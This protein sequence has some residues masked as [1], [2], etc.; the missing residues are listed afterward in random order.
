MNVKNGVQCTPDFNNEELLRYAVE[1]GMISVPHIQNILEMSRKE[2]YLKQHPY[3]IWQGKDGKWCTYLPDEDKGRKFIK[4]NTQQDVENFVADFY[5]KQEKDVSKTFI[6]VYHEWRFY[7]DQMVGDNSVAK[8]NSD[9]IRYFKNNKDAAKKIENYKKD[10]IKVFIRSEID[11]QKLC[12][13]AAKRLF[14]YIKNT[15]EFAEEHGYIEISPVRYLKAKDFYGY[16][17]QSERSKKEK[18]ISKKD[19]ITLAQRL[20]LDHQEMPNYIPSY[21]VELASLTGMRV[22]EISALTWD[23]IYD[24]F[25]LINKSEKYNTKEKC[26]YISSTKNGKERKFPLTPAIKKLLKRVKMVEMENGYLSEWVFSDQN[27]HVHF[28]KICSCIKAR[29]RQCGIDTKGIHAYRKTF[30]SNMEHD[31]IPSTVRASILGHSKEV[32]EAYYT[33]DIT[34][35][36]EK[37]NIVSKINEAMKMA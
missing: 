19:F 11:K 35:M 30:N 1:N 24:E 10:D 3:K 16:C 36:R 13:N 8:Y 32:N 25:I 27:G 29:C 22:G 31:G 26:Y 14:L 23:C 7:H 17:Y 15:F 37:N 20:Q 9:E 2:K 21:A 4:K 18:T 34:D 12:K 33:F 6:D 5:S 28:R